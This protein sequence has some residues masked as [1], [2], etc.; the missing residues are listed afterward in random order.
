MTLDTITKNGLRL[1]N[2]SGN[3]TVTIGTIVAK[4]CKEYA[5]AA[6][7]TLTS[8]NLTIGTVYYVNCGSGAVHANIKSG[9]G[10]TINELPAEAVA[11]AVEEN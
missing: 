1:Y 7:K 9:I 5:I 8:D 11:S 10:Q 3:P 4:N 2:N 6:Q